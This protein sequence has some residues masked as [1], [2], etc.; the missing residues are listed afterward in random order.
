MQNKF[1]KKQLRCVS[2]TQIHMK[3]TDFEI[4]FSLPLLLSMRS[5]LRA[6]NYDQ[7]TLIYVIILQS[8]LRLQRNG[9]RGK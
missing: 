4:I 6:P 8:L 3:A 2:I 9:E 7:R 1:A 5:Y